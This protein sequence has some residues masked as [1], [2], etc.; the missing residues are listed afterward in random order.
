MNLPAASSTSS[1]SDADACLINQIKRLTWRAGRV[2][3]PL[4]SAEGSRSHE[5]K[6]RADVSLPAVIQFFVFPN[7]KA[8]EGEACCCIEL[9]NRSSLQQPASRSHITCRSV[10]AVCAGSRP[11]SSCTGRTSATEAQR[12]RMEARRITTGSARRLPACARTVAMGCGPG[13]VEL[14]G[15]SASST[16]GPPPRLRSRLA[17]PPTATR[18][19]CGSMALGGR[20]VGDTPA[21][22]SFFCSDFEQ[23]EELGGE[24]GVAGDLE[25]GR[26]V[27]GAERLD[28]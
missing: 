23:V 8:R 22:D 18:A 3:V 27:F 28:P 10:I 21:A 26:G 2:S 7:V 4:A 9:L 25:V 6:R 13:A 14:G 16:P 11:P 1:S 17:A 5:G 15:C 12:Q 19:A 20:R 24:G